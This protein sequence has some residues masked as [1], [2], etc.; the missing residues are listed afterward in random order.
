MDR[1]L[2]R[3]FIAA[4]C[5]ASSSPADV[6]G[7]AA[8]DKA[9]CAAK[10][11]F[12]YPATQ[13]ELDA[14]LVVRGAGWG[15]IAA[16]LAPDH[17]SPPVRVVVIGGSM[18]CHA[19][20]RH[21]DGWPFVL[22][23]YM[24]RRY[25]GRVAVVDK[26]AAATSL[27]WAVNMA[28]KIV[29]GGVDVLL[30]DYVQNDGRPTLLDAQSDGLR[31][32]TDIDTRTR[33]GAEALLLALGRLSQLPEPPLVFFYATYPPPRFF[34]KYHRNNMR[35]WAKFW[36]DYD[37][38]KVKAY[39]K[40]LHGHADNYEVVATHYNATFAALQR[41]LWPDA[42]DTARATKLWV[43]DTSEGDWDHHP[44]RDA[45]RVVADS[46]FNAFQRLADGADGAPRR[47]S[48]RER[49]AG[50]ARSSTPSASAST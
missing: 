41:A 39:L 33:I 32:G 22:G 37:A 24:K 50:V 10:P 23:G 2:R 15:S 28:S 21:D 47:R 48:C 14:T 13:E 46:I 3:L 16:R 26:C 43:S 7:C 30:V 38:P 27:A 12:P 5:V 49:D 6:V 29:E 11:R 17:A 19:N 20:V 34:T 1:G 25:G 8:G 18:T 31:D 4:L 40:I 45:H 44:G 36:S 35:E 42:L 9:Y